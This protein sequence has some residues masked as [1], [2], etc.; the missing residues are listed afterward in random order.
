MN[1]DNELAIVVF[2]ML[3]IGTVGCVVG[4]WY[5]LER[6]INDDYEIV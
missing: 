6:R 2:I 3:A 5:K 1:E 4:I